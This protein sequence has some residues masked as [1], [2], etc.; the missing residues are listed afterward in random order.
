MERKIS[1]S[2]ELQAIEYDIDTRKDPSCDPFTFSSCEVTSCYY[3]YP[4]K[5]MVPQSSSNSPCL[6]IIPIIFGGGLVEGDHVN[7]SVR[8]GNSCCVLMTTI[9]FPK[10]L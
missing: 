6:W 1:A 8:V 10:I 4:L 5:L 7:I 9:S 2:I 3:E